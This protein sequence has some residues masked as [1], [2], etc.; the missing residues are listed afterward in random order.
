MFRYLAAQRL[1]DAVPV[2]SLKSTV[3]VEGKLLIINAPG[4]G[5]EIVAGAWCAENG[6]HAVIRRDMP[7]FFF[8]NF[9]LQS[10]C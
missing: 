9:C 4:N 5:D 7:M 6:K 1:R 8:I 10:C 2:S 3:A